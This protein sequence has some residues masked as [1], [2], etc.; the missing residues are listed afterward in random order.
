MLLRVIF[1]E[2]VTAGAAVL[3]SECCI[4]ALNPGVGI[5]HRESR[6]ERSPSTVQ[7]GEMPWRRA[8][9]TFAPALH[10]IR[11]A[12]TPALRCTATS[13]LDRVQEPTHSCCS[14]R[15]RPLASRSN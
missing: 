2:T 4:Q 14:C 12:T 15:A 1:K 6:G 11:A 7:G 3:Q 13:R 5:A 10:L 8:M 9:P